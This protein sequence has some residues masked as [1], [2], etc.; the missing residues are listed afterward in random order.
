VGVEFASLY[1][2]FG[3]DVTLVELLDRIVP[4][5]DA[6]ISA[7]IEKA[8][9]HRGI[10]VMTSTKADPSSLKKTEDGVTIKVEGEDSEETLEAEVLLVAVGRT[11]VVDALNLDATEVQLDDPGQIQVD[12]FYRTAEPGVYAAGDVIGGYWLAHAAAHEGI[13]AVEHMAGQDPLPIDQNLIPRVT[14][15]RPEVA[16][17][18]LTKQQA[19]EQG[20]QVKESKFPFRAIGKALIE[21]DSDG[22]LKIVVDADSNLIL[23]MHAIGPH[24]TELIA[25]GSFAKLVEGTPEEL[26]MNVHAHPSLSEIVGEAAMA[27]DG[28]AIH[29]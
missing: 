18:G 20:H 1:N 17:F 26:G 21:G 15:C 6:E 25:E 7:E 29:F 24:V 11:T 4:A 10:R 19:E 28:L 13:V 5:E 12:E 27:V 22:F 9:E 3:T 14:F 2:D 23:G 16:S 8:F